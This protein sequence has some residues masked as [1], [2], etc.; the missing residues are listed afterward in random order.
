MYGY[1]TAAL[2]RTRMFPAATHGLRNELHLGLKRLYKAI[3]RTRIFFGQ[4]P[5]TCS[6]AIN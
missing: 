4:G 2:P 1:M 3:R 6:E 5:S